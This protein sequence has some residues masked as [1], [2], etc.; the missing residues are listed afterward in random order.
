LDF[1][2]S[3]RVRAMKAIVKNLVDLIDK[4]HWAEDFQRA[5]ER[6]QAA[7][8]PSIAAIRSLDDY[9]AFIDDLLTWVP[10]QQGNRMMIYEK[11]VTFYFFL[12]QEPLKSL[13]S[14]AKPESAQDLTPLSKW[15]DDYAKAW[16][17]YMD[18]PESA[19]EVESFRSDPS[20]RW[21]EYMPP[22]SGYLTFNQ[23]FARHT[24]PGLRPVAEPHRHSVIVSPADSTFAGQWSVDPKSSIYIENAT[25]EVKGI[26]WSIEQLLDGSR[27]AKEFSGGLFTHCFLNNFDYHRFHTPVAGTV[28]EARL[29]KGQV[30]L[31]VSVKQAKVDGTMV[32]VLSADDGTGYQFVQMR[33]LAILDSPI[34]LVACLPV[35]MAQVSSIVFTAEAGRTLFKGEELGYFQFGG[36]DFIMVFQRASGVELTAQPNVHYL[37]G[38]QI[39][40]AVVQNAQA[41]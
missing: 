31:D 27:Y 1:F 40:R 37:Q 6:A 19:A 25:L 39:G 16:G 21:D 30:R 4:H 24:K 18:T 38:A 2:G 5:I 29:I 11:I 33:G 8:V 36:S 28:L 35:G 22:P 12:D 26:R 7:D 32:N 3:I 23:F 17:Q 41:R 20:F 10:R 13:Q 15:V 34:G 9:L 14:S